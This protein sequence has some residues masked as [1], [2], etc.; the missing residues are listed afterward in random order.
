[1]TVGTRDGLGIVARGIFGVRLEYELE[2]VA[3][4]LEAMKLNVAEN[5]R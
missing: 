4:Q 2:D 3:V 5:L 1:M